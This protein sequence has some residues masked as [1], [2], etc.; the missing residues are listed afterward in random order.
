MGIR[1]LARQRALQF[2]YALEFSS[3]EQGFLEVQRLFLGADAGRRKGWDEFAEALAEKAYSERRELDQEIKPFLRNW[4]LERLPKIDLL[5]L[6]MALCELRYFPD[7]PLRVTINEYIDLSR[8]FST[9]ESPQYINAML[10]QLAKK[11]PQKDFQASEEGEAR[12]K[13]EEG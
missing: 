3:P 5:C 1:H 9:D 8:V 13:G 6:R 2:L 12:P 11:F 10:D 4:T 7:I